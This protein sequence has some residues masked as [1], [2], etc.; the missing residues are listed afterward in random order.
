MSDAPVLLSVFPPAGGAVNFARDEALAQVARNT[1]HAVMRLYAWDRPVVS[2][3]RNERAVGRYDPDKLARAGLD[4]VRRPTGG[5]ALLHHHELTYAFAEQITDADSLRASYERVSRLLLTALRTLGVAADVADSR[6][7]RPIEGS[8]CFAIPSAGEIVVDGR[9]LVASAQWRDAQVYLQHGSILID[10]D[11]PLLVRGLADGVVMPP[12][13]APATL[14]E[15][16]GR[17][18]SLEELASGVAHSLAAGGHAPSRVAPETLIPVDA[19]REHRARY[20]DPAWTW[21]R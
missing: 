3:G 13:P 7:G 1:G 4:V 14:R 11:Q 15:I 2:L 12:L 6:A 17:A 16:L 10:D 9:K 5:R 21:R 20:D 18:P 19:E 8:P